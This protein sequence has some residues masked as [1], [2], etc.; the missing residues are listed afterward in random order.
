MRDS[1]EF[2]TVAEVAVI[3][4]VSPKTIRRLI[5]SGRLRMIK[6]P[7]VRRIII[8]ADALRVYLAS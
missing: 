3:L 2:L 4:R 6:L 1:K 5:T 8:P 7:G